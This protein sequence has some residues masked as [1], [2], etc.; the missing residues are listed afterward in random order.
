MKAGATRAAAACLH[1]V[2]LNLSTK[3]DDSARAR[4][5]FAMLLR[6]IIGRVEI[7]PGFIMM[8]SLLSFFRRANVG[9][10]NEFAVTP[11]L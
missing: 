11:S 3:I 4:H 10:K 9:E 7:T 2:P 8:S 5:R 1:F 6:L